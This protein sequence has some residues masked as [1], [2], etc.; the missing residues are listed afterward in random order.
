MNK[1]IPEVKN[2]TSASGNT[3][4]N[5]FEIITAKGRYF[6]SYDTIIAA[7]I[8]GKLYLDSNSWDYSRTTSKY[9]NIFTGLDTKETEKLIKNGDIELVNL[10]N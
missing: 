3:I 2:M 10:N 8:D 1:L 4:A 7:Y 5:Q 6:Q 9:R